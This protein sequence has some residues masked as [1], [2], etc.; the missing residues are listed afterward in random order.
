MRPSQAVAVAFLV[1]VAESGCA[2]STPSTTASPTGTRERSF[3]SAAKALIN[4][5]V[6]VTFRAAV[7]ALSDVPLDLRLVDENL[8]AVETPYFDLTPHE[9][10]AERYPV[11]ERLVRL[12]VTVQPDTLGRGSRVAIFVLYQVQRMGMAVG[13]ATER[14]VPADHPGAGF[15]R[16]LLDRIERKAVGTPERD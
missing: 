2:G 16:K 9:W 14:A 8:G 6:Q 15:A 13:R 12:R 11:D 4:A 7:A 5:S 10:R 3:P 1:V